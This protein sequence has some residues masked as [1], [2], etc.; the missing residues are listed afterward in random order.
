MVLVVIGV[1]SLLVQLPVQL[2]YAM[3]WCCWHVVP[4][5]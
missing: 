1:R 4:L 2:P 3:M 5:L